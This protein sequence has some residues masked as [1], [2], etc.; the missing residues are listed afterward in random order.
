M[1]PEQEQ[2]A[3]ASKLLEMHGNEV[4]TYIMRRMSDLT[5]NDDREGVFFW[6]AIADKVMQLFGPD[7]EAKP[8]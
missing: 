1:T 6:I 4:G 3:F 5:D 2:W 7:E 8:Q